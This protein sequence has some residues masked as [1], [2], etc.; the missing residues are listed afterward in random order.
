MR[1]M[2]ALQQTIRLKRQGVGTAAHRQIET[3]RGGLYIA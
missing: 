1:C 2:K 3:A